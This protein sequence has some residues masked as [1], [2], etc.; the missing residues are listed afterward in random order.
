MKN[1]FF[2]SKETGAELKPCL[3]YH[4]SDIPLRYP[5]YAEACRTIKICRP[6]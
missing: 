2:N 4:I 5:W 1:K 3:I 6:Y